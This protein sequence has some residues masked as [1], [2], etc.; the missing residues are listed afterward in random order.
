MRPTELLQ[1]IRKMRFE[2]IFSVW[3]EGYIFI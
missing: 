1:G 3:T 2:E